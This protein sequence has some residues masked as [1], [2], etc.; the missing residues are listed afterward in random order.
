MLNA[1]LIGLF[2]GFN[3]SNTWIFPGPEYFQ[4]LKISRGLPREQP[5]EI[6]RAWKFPGGDL[7]QFP[8]NFQVAKN[9]IFKC[10]SESSC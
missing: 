5:L 8:G 3:N 7:W 10:W 9:L 6:F 1:K 2:Q 4:V